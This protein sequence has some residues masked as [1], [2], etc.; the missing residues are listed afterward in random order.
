MPLFDLTT[1]QEPFLK[2]AED[3][4]ENQL[5]PNADTLDESA[6]FPKDNFNALAQSG[7]LGLRIPKDLGGMGADVLTSVLVIERLSRAC[8][9]TGMCFK[10]HCE[11]TEPIWRM[12]TDDQK[13]RF[14]KPIANGERIATTAIAEAGTRSHTWSLQSSIKPVDG[15]YDLTN[16]RKGWVTSSEYADLYFTPAML[17]DAAPGYFT[18]F[19]LEKSEVEWSVDAPWKGLGMRANASSPMTFSGT[20]PAGNRLGGESAW[21][22]EVLPVLMPFSMITF[23]AVYL[24]IAEGAYATC[25][26][27]VTGRAY[28]DTGLSW[29]RSTVSNGTLAK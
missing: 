24:G 14:V 17:D 3:L 26:D 8:G 10:M 23:A 28:G 2:I 25:L 6:T 7:L 11:S 21:P 27:H 4:A 13:D 5:R 22:T 9:S 18:S 1:D 16:V 19:V 15:G 12:A 20:V 29:L